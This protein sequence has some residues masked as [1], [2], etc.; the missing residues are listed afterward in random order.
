MKKYDCIGIGSPL[1]DLTFNVTDDILDELGLKKGEMCLIDKEKSKEILKKLNSL[2]KD[3]SPGGCCSNTVAGISAL[4]GKAVFLGKIGN[5]VHGEIYESKTKKQGVIT[6]LSKHDSEITGH[7]ITFITPDFE[8]TFATHLGA[9]LYLKKQDII[10]EEIKNSKILHIEAYQLEDPSLRE[11][12]LHAIEIAKKN[13][14]L[15]SMDLADPA[16]VLRNLDFLKDFIKNSIDIVFANETEAQA[17]TGKEY[18]QALLEISNIC[19]IAV[20]KLG[21]KGS[22]IK[23]K[24][25]IH[26]IPS[27]KVKTVNTNGAGDMYAAGVLYGVVNN[28]SFEETGKLASFAASLVVSNSDT[29]LNQDQINKIKLINSNRPENNK[30]KT[31]K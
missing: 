21:E 22:L 20:V 9:S 11:I 29:R 25:I 12:N 30:W 1:L 16:L 19:N 7:S 10:D 4:G 18:K 17:F 23:Y 28:L 3:V 14:V 6:R 13:N 5:D 31:T 2:N 27:F 24:D 26:E 8:R 15:V